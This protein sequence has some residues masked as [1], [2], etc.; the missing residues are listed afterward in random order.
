MTELRPSRKICLWTGLRVHLSLWL[1]V[2]LG[3]L[4]SNWP[5]LFPNRRWFLHLIL[6][7]GVATLVIF[8][9]PRAAPKAK[10]L[11]HVASLVALLLV[12]VEIGLG[13]A[14]PDEEVAHT[15]HPYAYRMHGVTP[16]LAD[17]GWSRHASTNDLGL[18]GVDPVP[19]KSEREF[20]V[21]ILGG[22]A[23]FGVGSPD[24]D[25][26]GVLLEAA[27][28]PVL[29][30]R[31][32]IDRVTVVN[33]GQPWYTTTQE[34]IFFLTDL[35]L[36]EPD[37]VI[38]LDGYNDAHHTVLWG[39]RPP[40]NQVATDILRDLKILPST[41]RKEATFGLALHATVRASSLL[42]VLGIRPESV[43]ALPGFEPPDW[44][45]PE[46]TR[47]DEAAMRRRL[48]MN[49]TLMHRLGGAMGFRTLF[50]MQPTIYTK[51]SLGP[52]ER[53]WVSAHDYVPL[54]TEVW[55][56]LADSAGE[57]A[58]RLGLALFECDVHLRDREE[59]LFLDYCHLGP[60]GNR[61][62]MKAVAE[63]VE[64]EM[65]HWPWRADYAGIR[66]R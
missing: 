47:R 50:S 51:A 36:L 44:R 63:R 3:L 33:G 16:G 4:L 25:S 24:A 11:L 21:L 59:D 12:L 38:M 37:L 31:P 40:A 13:A 5:D 22:S 7:G 55:A 14:S 57:A 65:A 43:L 8:W 30:L 23:V 34:L 45:R 41:F 10:L 49:W 28:R 27:L 62:W 29:S 19:P 46:P 1:L 54:M 56:G 52:A 2:A 53:D 17:G 58:S 64:A 39:N 6:A 48:V 35:S 42:D 15:R 20:R 60:D 61:L 32:G 18:R 9:I 26:P 66:A